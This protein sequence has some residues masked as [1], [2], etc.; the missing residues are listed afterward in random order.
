MQQQIRAQKVCSLTLR[1]IIRAA[2]WGRRWR[3]PP[4]SLPLSLSPRFYSA[5]FYRCEKP[6]TS[7]TYWFSFQPCH[8]AFFTVSLPLSNTVPALSS[9]CTITILD[10]WGSSEAF[11]FL[12]LLLLRSPLVLSDCWYFPSGHTLLSPPACG[13]CSITLC[14]VW[15]RLEAALSRLHRGSHT[16]TYTH[17]HTLCGL[18]PRALASVISVDIFVSSLTCHS[19]IKLHCW[20][21]IWIRAVSHCHH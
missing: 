16:H 13:C 3:T 17:T 9:S 5:G 10:I 19:E 14:I 20:C 4:F 2:E 15:Q 12:L 7:E 6:K 18:A 8:Y 11:Y 1:S 21:F